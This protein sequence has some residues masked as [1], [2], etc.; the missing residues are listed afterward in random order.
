MIPMINFYGVS[1]PFRWD[2]GV[3]VYGKILRIPF[4]YFDMHTENWK[5]REYPKQT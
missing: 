5:L 3:V 2:F 1:K 4:C